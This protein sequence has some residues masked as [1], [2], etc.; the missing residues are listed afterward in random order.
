MAI[1]PEIYSCWC[2]GRSGGFLTGYAPIHV[3][4][5]LERAELLLLGTN[6]IVPLGIMQPGPGVVAW[7]GWLTTCGVTVPLVKVR[8][9]MP[10]VEF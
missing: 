7:I 10:V 3:R 6:V 1:Q 5:C 9:D 2:F 4:S 8:G